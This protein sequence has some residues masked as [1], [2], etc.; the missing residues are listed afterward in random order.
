MPPRRR[1][2]AAAAAAVAAPHLVS[3]GA[4]MVAGLELWR[5]EGRLWLWDRSP[6]GRFAADV[7][8][9]TAT[10]AA[11]GSLNPATINLIKS[12]TPDAVPAP[13]P[14]GPRS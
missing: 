2:A 6:D 12:Y 3:T 13:T 1:F 10:A 5:A 8:A 11:T 4:G 14:A 9:W 7:A